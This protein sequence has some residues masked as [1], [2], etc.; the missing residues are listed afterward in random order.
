MKAR[1]FV[2][3]KIIRYEESIYYANV[4]NFKY[5]IMKLVGINPAEVMNKVKKE[6]SLIEKSLKAA[7]NEGF[8]KKLKN[9]FSKNSKVGVQEI[10]DVNSANDLESQINN[11]EK[12]KSLLNFK[13]K[14]LVIDCS[15]VN[16]I[17]SQ[18]VNAIL[19]VFI[20]PFLYKPLSINF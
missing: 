18:G 14:H 9:R 3:I 1:E 11:N 8:I 6:K 2:D 15:C 4:D 16:F 5:K 19:Q 13:I 17:D 7:N 12:I 20:F 10:P